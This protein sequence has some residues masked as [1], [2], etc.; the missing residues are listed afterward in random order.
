MNKGCPPPSQSLLQWLPDEVD[1]SPVK[2]IKIAIWSGG[3][4]QHRRRIDNLTKIQVSIIDGTTLGR[5]TQKES[6]IKTKARLRRSRGTELNDPHKTVR[7][8]I[9]SRGDG[10]SLGV[11]ERCNGC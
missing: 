6:A 7:E 9:S 1:P 10:N 5:S 11:P 4:N 3:M 8:R 2:E